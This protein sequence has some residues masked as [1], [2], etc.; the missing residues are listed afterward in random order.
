MCF[1]DIV[2]K[3]GYHRFIELFNLTVSLRV[4]R[5]Y[6][7]VLETRKP[8]YCCEEFGH[9]L[10]SIARTEIGKDDLRYDPK[11]LE[12]CLHYVLMLFP[13]TK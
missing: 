6:G 10:C 13:K 12:R 8:T 7:K 9:G 11:D 1:C 3:S 2:S 4:V 5:H